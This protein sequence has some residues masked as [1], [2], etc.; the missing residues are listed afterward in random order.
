MVKNK[1]METFESVYVYQFSLYIIVKPCV[2]SHSFSD[3][4]A[5]ENARNIWYIFGLFGVFTV[6]CRDASF[7][8]HVGLILLRLTGG[9]TDIYKTVKYIIHQ[10]LAM[11]M[12]INCFLISQIKRSFSRMFWPKWQSSS[13]GIVTI[14]VS[15][16]HVEFLS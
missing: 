14:S 7:I 9:N 16:F 11:I 8:V 4:R 12:N 5:G 6:C 15:V 1:H 3:T 2:R 13:P 10:C